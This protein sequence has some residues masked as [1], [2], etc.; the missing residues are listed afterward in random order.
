MKKISVKK[1]YTG[2]ELLEDQIVLFDQKIEAIRPRAEADAVAAEDLG[3]CTIMTPGFI[4]LHIHGSAGADVMD[5]T[6]EALKTIAR[7]LPQFG[8]TSFLATTMTETPEAI[9][10]A[11][12]NVRA[13]R[14]QQG[15]EPEAEILGVHLEG[16]FLSVEKCG[17]QDP[18][19]IVAPTPE[20]CAYLEPYYDLIRIITVAPE[21]DEDFTMIRSWAERGIIPSLGH[22]NCSYE[23]AEAAHQ[24]GLQHV[25]HCFNAMTGLHHRR[26]GAV[27]AALTLPLTCEMIVDG[28]H[29]A[30][31]IVR[32]ICQAKARDERILITDA[33]RAAGLGNC[34]SEL[35]GQKV[36]VQ[37]G[38]ATLADGTLAGSVL[39]LHRAL[40]N[41]LEFTGLDL[42]EVVEMLSYNPA[43]RL[44]LE[45]QIGQIQPGAAADFNCFSLG[46]AL[47]ACYKAGQACAL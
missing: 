21:C 29:L 45:S 46:L 2:Q 30:P 22:T 7:S 40:Q 16:P 32:L 11:L 5:A 13:Y 41:T 26:S 19:K 37:D 39:D 14:A 24:A 25:T 43:K 34:E 47:E 10:A 12:D 8:C 31:P 20:N 36:Y 3:E 33:M 44:G 38:R 18:S 35:G 1:L 15:G 42:L 23:T 28:E 27:G 4:D 17:A 6:A 9:T